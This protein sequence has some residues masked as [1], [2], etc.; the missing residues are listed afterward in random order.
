VGATYTGT[1]FYL[2]FKIFNR[3]TA[4]FSRTIAQKMRSGVR[5][6][7]FWDEKGVILKFGGVLP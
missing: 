4:Q 7:L 2:F 1:D 6:T 5:K 3:A